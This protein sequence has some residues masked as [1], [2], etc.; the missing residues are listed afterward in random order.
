M[1]APEQDSLFLGLG[2]DGKEDVESEAECRRS[3]GFADQTLYEGDALKGV[4]GAEGYTATPAPMASI[5]YYASRDSKTCSSTT[6]C[7]CS[8]ARK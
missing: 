6:A 1:R 4:L 5:R 3:V 7:K 8:R 2:K